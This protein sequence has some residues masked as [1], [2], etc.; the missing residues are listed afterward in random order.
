[1]TIRRLSLTDRLFG[2]AQ[3]AVQVLAAAPVSSRASP[4]GRYSAEEDAGL[5]D[6]Q[7]QASAAMMRVNHVGEVC[8]QALYEGQGIVARSPEIRA[9]LD[10]AAV[11]ERDHLAWTAERLKE[12]NARPSLLN[13]FWYGASFVMGVAAGRLGD[14]ASMGFMMETERQV[15]RHLEG[16]LAALPAADSRS[17]SIVVQMKQDEAEHGATARRMGGGPLPGPARLV[18]QGVA[19]V[20]TTTARWI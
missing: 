18:M 16:H 10:H 6:Q 9:S 13:P 2:T 15:E 17:R 3:R 8:A 12:L 14:R 19:K 1:M 4:A 5:S 11:E 20:M 7:K